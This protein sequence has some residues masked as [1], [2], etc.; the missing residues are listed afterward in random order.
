MQGS[1]VELA[2]ACLIAVVTFSA[3]WTKSVSRPLAV[4]WSAKPAQG[5][6]LDI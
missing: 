2:T 5:N 3:P 1:A 4:T 6:M